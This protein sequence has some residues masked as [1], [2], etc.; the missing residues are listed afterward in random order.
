[1]P[2]GCS[3]IRRPESPGVGVEGACAKGSFGIE[4]R[5]SP[6]S[7]DGPTRRVCLFF[8]SLFL[9]ASVQDQP[10]DH[11]LWELYRNH[12]KGAKYVDLTFALSPTSPGWPGFDHATFRAATASPSLSTSR[13]E[14]PTRP[15]ASSPRAGA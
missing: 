11:R 5:R 9:V 7:R 15:P 10:D 14:T 4:F 8:M 2:S 1:M 3:G 13:R 6:Q 12:V